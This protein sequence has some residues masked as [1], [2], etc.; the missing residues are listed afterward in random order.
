MLFGAHFRQQVPIRILL[1]WTDRRIAFS[2][3]FFNKGF[4]LDLMP[5]PVCE[6]EEL[7]EMWGNN[8]KY[9]KQ[10]NK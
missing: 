4:G 7:G 5:L 3:S 1:R 6:K 8:V 2:V 9:Y 10:K